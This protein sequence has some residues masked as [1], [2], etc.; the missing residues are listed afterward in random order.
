M[1][2]VETV[3]C[4]Y[5]AICVFLLRITFYGF[6]SQL[7][8]PIYKKGDD[9]C[10]IVKDLAR[11][12]KQDH[13]E[14]LLHWQDKLRQLGVDF[15]SQ[16]IP[17]QQLKQEYRQ[18]EMKLKLANRFDRF[19]VDARVD[20]H[21][22]NFL[23]SVFIRRC[24]NATPVI[25][26][27]DEKVVKNLNKVLGKVTYKQ[28][29]TGRTTEIQFATHKMPLEAAVE[30]AE[31]LI[32][33]MKNQFPG[34]WLNIRTIYLK[35]MTDIPVT[36]PLYV[37]NIDPNLVPVPKI[38]GPRERFEKSNN[39][40]LLKITKNKYK[41]QA[42]NLVRV[43]FEQRKILNKHRVDQT[44]EEKTEE[45]EKDE[46]SGENGSDDEVTQD[47]RERASDTEQSDLDD[48]DD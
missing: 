41:F 22:F 47:P 11:G 36:F 21:V 39:E 16:V 17:L 30:N 12:R 2:R 27:K 37:S 34:G 26:D 8:N 24:K 45:G 44:M 14:T 10:L 33:A 18:Y 6:Y 23:G 38:P 3:E 42:G 28:T 13:E 4:E 15:I 48:N 20:G 46:N 1:F 5:S 7:P 9:I 35:P 31:A 29:N 32:M 25:L 43:P 40:K 19:L